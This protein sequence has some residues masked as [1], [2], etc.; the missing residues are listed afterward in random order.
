M[1]LFQGQ[2]FFS[3]FFRN[4]YISMAR[5]QV[6]SEKPPDEGHIAPRIFEG[7]SVLIHGRRKKLQNGGQ[8]QVSE[9]STLMMSCLMAN[10]TRSKRE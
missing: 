5:N 6:W 1:R 4:G 3:G 8:D 9:R 10:L 7:G 2:E